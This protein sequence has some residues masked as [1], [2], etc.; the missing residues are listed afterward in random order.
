MVNALRR[1]DKKLLDLALQYLT[2]NAMSAMFLDIKVWCPKSCSVAS[3]KLSFKKFVFN[4]FP[5]QVIC[6][7]SLGDLNKMDRYGLC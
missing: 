5:T 2:K 4:C 6:C 3:S 7:I 1:V